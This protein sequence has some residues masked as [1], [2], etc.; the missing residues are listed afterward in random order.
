MYRVKSINRRKGDTWDWVLGTGL[1][2]VQVSVTT[3]GATQR[4]M[5]ERARRKCR[6][7]NK[8]FD[9][10]DLKDQ[11]VKLDGKKPKKSTGGSYQTRN[12]NSYQVRMRN[13]SVLG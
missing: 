12:R 5:Y 4:S 10:G 2:D 8:Q 6:S 1:M 3:P 7:L 11:L 13:W 9:M